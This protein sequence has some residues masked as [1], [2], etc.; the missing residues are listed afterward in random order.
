MTLSEKEQTFIAQRISHY[1]IGYRRRNKLTQAGLAKKLKM[2]KSSICRFEKVEQNSIVNSLTTICEL[3]ALENQSLV[4][5][6]SY[7]LKEEISPGHEVLA[8]WQKTL[9]QAMKSLDQIQRLQVCSEL[10]PELLNEKEK[11]SDLFDCF[12]ML[13]KLSLKDLKTARNFIEL[14]R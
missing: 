9:L 5:F 11:L 2:T 13:G 4:K 10:L 3:A 6:V 14:I 1:L 12:L 7:L 8:P